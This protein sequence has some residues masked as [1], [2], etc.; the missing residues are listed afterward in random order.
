MTDCDADDARVFLSQ[1][2]YGEITAG[3]ARAFW[4]AT[5]RPDSHVYHGY[6]EGSLLAANFNGLWCDALNLARQGIGPRYFAMQHADV[7][8][9]DWWL[10]TLIAEM[11]T[12]DLDLLGVAVPIKDPKGLTSIALARPDGDPWRPLCRL[13]L[14]EVHRLPETFTSADVGGHPLL[15]NTGLWVCRFDEAWARQVRF[16]IND[17]IVVDPSGR[18]VPQCEPEDWYFSRLC[19]ELDLKVGATR[20]IRLTHRGSAAFSN[21]QPWGQPFDSAWIGQSVLPEPPPPPD[22]FTLPDIP[23]WLRIEEGAKLAELARGKRVLEVGSY[24]GLSTVCLAR[25]AESVLAIDPH[26]GRGTEVPQDTLPGFRANLARYGLEN[27]FVE[28]M[29]L[30]EYV[31]TERRTRTFWYDLI[32][33]DGAHD[34]DSVEADIRAILDDP[35][36]LADGGL[37]AFHDYRSPVDPGVTAAVDA[38]L[39]RGG[40][41]LSLTGSLA[42]VRPPADV[43]STLEV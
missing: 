33:I 22:G 29:T 34:R 39:D 11:E 24:L 4:R 21:A 30:A 15:L 13:T 25:T 3:S 20:K 37:I 40:E 43:L 31:A 2:G 28:P 38:L 41:L 19:H 10:D 18:Y 32:F 12:H 17:R 23:G 9:E 5:R 16:T 42:V 36:M 14:S 1:P 7:E 26:D 35:Y 27:V 8:P 6:R